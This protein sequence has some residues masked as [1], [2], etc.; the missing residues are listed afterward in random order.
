MLLDCFYETYNVG[1]I[2]SSVM[3][4]NSFVKILR[5][6]WIKDYFR[7]EHITVTPLSSSLIN[8]LP[9]YGKIQTT[10]T[11]LLRTNVN[12]TPASKEKLKWD[13]YIKS[14]MYNSLYKV[15]LRKKK[16]KNREY[17]FI[18]ANIDLIWT[19]LKKIQTKPLS[20]I[21]FS[22]LNFNLFLNLAS[23]FYNSNLIK[24]ICK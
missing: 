17:R 20:M 23:I 21:L 11:K 22:R 18:G 9:R 10:K 3:F 19:V 8:V 5:V 15:L 24:Y 7:C 14:C 1:C 6:G 12:A 16:I 13:E 2:V 4:I